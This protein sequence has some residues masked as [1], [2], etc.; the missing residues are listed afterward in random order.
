MKE[1][2]RFSLLILPRFQ[3]TLIFQSLFVGVLVAL[4]CLAANHY[5]FWSYLEKGKS[6]GIPIGHPY[7]T[8]IEELQYSTPNLYC[9]E[10]PQ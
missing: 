10:A 9:L 2:K 6:L 3:L 4:I 5:F 8:F 1:N 7:F